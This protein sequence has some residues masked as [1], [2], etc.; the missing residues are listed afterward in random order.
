[1]ATHSDLIT[2]SD[3]LVLLKNLVSSVRYQ[4]NA[5]NSLAGI[6]HLTIHWDPASYDISI[7]VA[8][9]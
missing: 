9:A 2:G 3:Q 4:V 5:K 6:K 7:L 1:M 8:I